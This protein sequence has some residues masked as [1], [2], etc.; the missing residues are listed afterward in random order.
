MAM[1]CG[2]SVSRLPIPASGKVTIPVQNASYEVV[3]RNTSENR[4]GFYEHVRCL[5]GALAMTPAR[6]AQF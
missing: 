6:Q 3:T 5:S 1:Q 2:N 4:N